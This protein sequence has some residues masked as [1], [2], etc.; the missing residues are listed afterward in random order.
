MLDLQKKN[1]KTK[2][3]ML[4]NTHHIVTHKIQTMSSVV[5][6]KK[7]THKLFIM[8]KKIFLSAATISSIREMNN[9]QQLY[10]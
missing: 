9:L 2:Q 1:A 4:K 7:V 10:L 3:N 8:S 5:Y 6:E